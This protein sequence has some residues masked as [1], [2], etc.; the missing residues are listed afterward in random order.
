MLRW[1]PERIA[2]YADKSFKRLVRF[3]YEN[4]EFYRAEMDK[5]GIQPQDVSGVEDLLRFRVIGKEDINA[6]GPKLI[7]KD[8]KPL[9]SFHTSGT[10]KKSG[11]IHY[12]SEAMKIVDSMNVFNFFTGAKNRKKSN[13][14][15]VRLLGIVPLGH[16]SHVVIGR[17]PKFIADIDFI[18]IGQPARKLVDKFIEYDPHF[19]YCY[20][21][22]LL[23]MAEYMK[24]NGIQVPDSLVELS[25]TAEMLED[26]LKQ[27]L[28]DFYKVPVLNLYAAVETIS[29]AKTCSR[30]NLHF[31]LP[32]LIHTEILDPETQEPARAG[33][34]VIT[35]LFNYCMPLIRY[36]LCDYVEVCEEP[37]GCGWTTGVITKIRGRT[38]TSVLLPNGKRLLG[39]YFFSLVDKVPQVL[40]YQIVQNAPGSLICN[41][42]LDSE[43]DE[44]DSLKQV[45]LTLE[46]FTDNT[47]NV[48]VNRVDNLETKG[49]T[50][51]CPQIISSL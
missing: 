44:K 20:P 47:M 46:D 21:S 31:T 22:A 9:F 13:E 15:K 38:N 19:V 18:D 26:S 11:E 34:V 14:G 40:F 50:L 16:C 5:I 30:G 33:N 41:V 45:Q 23:S 36:N 8:R 43:A 32:G 17:T 24:E 39:A 12:D 42:M 48:L 6:A 51:K 27:Y 7:S 35:N 1:P 37:C 25:S 29:Y 4:N 28:E 2:V 10:S 49:L 3:V